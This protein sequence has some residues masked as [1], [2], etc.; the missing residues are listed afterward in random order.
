MQSTEVNRRVRKAIEA[1]HKRHE[2]RREFQL[3]CVKH[4]IETRQHGMEDERLDDDLKATLEEWGAALLEFTYREDLLLRFIDERTDGDV[5]EAKEYMQDKMPTSQHAWKKA[6]R[7][8]A[9]NKHPL[10][11]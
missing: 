10:E 5:E 8:Q 11:K 7:D 6:M 2:F 4:C 1:C 9:G 3:F